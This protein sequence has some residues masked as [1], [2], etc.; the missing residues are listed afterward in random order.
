MKKK[1]YF[2]TLVIALLTFTG[3]ANDEYVGD[4]QNLGEQN[5]AIAFSTKSENTVRGTTSDLKAPAKLTN[6]F[7]VYGTKT[8]GSTEHT[9]FNNYKVVY[10]SGTASSS[11][12]SGWE[13]VNG[14]NQTIKYWDYSASKYDFEAYSYNSTTGL[15][16]KITT[17]EEATSGLAVNDYVVENMS[18]DDYDNLYFSEKKTVQKNS[19]I[20]G[21]RYQDAVKLTF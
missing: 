2:A 5:G 20:V 14:T 10:Q 12:T 6:Q 19:I 3:C 7:W 18:G 17:T 16:K 13:Y 8:V 9:V 11:N 1:F 4:Q 21:E 15:V